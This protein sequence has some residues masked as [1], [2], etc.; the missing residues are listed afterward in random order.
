MLRPTSSL[1]VPAARGVGPLLLALSLA[2]T[3]SLHAAITC[4][5]STDGKTFEPAHTTVSQ[6]RRHKTTELSNTYASSILSNIPV[7]VRVR[8]DKRPP[9]AAVFLPQWRPIIARVADGA[10][11]FELKPNESVLV[12]FGGPED[13]SIG[14][15]P[16]KT[17]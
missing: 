2:A 10:V 11:Y 15:A 1:T 17:Y 9:E 5:Y 16:I 8:S 12:K 3:A 14:V 4:D 7:T 6:N 13:I